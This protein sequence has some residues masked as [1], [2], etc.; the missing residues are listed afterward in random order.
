MNFLENFF[1]EILDT[2]MKTTYH[3]ALSSTLDG[4]LGLKMT[5]L[6]L[7]IYGTYKKKMVKY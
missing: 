7:K 1:L 6:L 2:Q 4:L 3:G 5:S